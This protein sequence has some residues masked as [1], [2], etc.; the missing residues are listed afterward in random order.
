MILA[1]L[2]ASRAIVA[3][4]ALSPAFSRVNGGASGI[5]LTVLLLGVVVKYR[6]GLVL[7]G[8]APVYTPLG[9]GLGCKN[10]YEIGCLYSI[11]TASALCST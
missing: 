3:F 10:R 7:S 4:L 9:Y 6:A 8:I 2:L 5:C 1:S 11:A